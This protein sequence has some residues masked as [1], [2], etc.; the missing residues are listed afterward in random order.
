MFKHYPRLKKENSIAAV[1]IHKELLLEK[2]ASEFNYSF[3]EEDSQLI[4]EVTVLSYANKLNL[5]IITNQ[6]NDDGV[7]AVV[8]NGLNISGLIGKKYNREKTI[9][10]AF[11]YFDRVMFSII[12]K[13]ITYP[14]VANYGKHKE[15]CV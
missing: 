9:R 10:G 1:E 13:G 4:N 6:I 11:T 7:R 2:Y 14:K 15:Q 5:S 3:V 8:D 12:N